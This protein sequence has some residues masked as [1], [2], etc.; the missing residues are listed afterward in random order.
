MV[1]PTTNQ[2]HSLSLTFQFLGKE[3][4]GSRA[5]IVTFGWLQIQSW[6]CMSSVN[7]SSSL[8]SA[9]ESGGDV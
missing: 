5:C 6:K 2:V 8:M 9:S 1:L 4:E 7:Q 3:V